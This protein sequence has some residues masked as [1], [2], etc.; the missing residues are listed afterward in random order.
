MA[1]FT[2]RD[3][4]RTAG[5]AAAALSLA[6]AV[7]ARAADRAIRLFWWGNPDRDKRTFEVIRS[8]QE[9]HPG[10]QVSGETIGWSDYWTK[11][12]TQTAGRNMPDL[13][14]MDY[15]YLFEYVRRGALKPLDDHIGKSLMIGTFDK[16]AVDGGRVDGKLYALNI[17]SNSQVMVYNAKAFEAAGVKPDIYAW[18]Y[19]DYARVCE[20]VT[21]KSGGRM[22]GSDDLSLNIDMLE[23]WIRQNGREFYDADGKVAATVEDAATF[24]QY[25]AGLRKAGVVRDKNKTVLVSPPLSETGIVTGEA[26]IGQHWSNQLVGIQALM[27]DPIGAAMVP[28]MQNGKPGQFIKP[29]QFLS[30]S[31]DA[32]DVEAAMLLLNGWVTDPKLTAIL[33]ME[34][35]IPCSPQVRAALKP[36]LKPVEALSI[37][38][39]Q[40]IQD[41]VA[42]LPPPPPKGAGE[43]REAFTRIGTEVVLDRTSPR[44]AAD[45][46]IDEAG[47]ILERAL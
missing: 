36:S 7:P 16:A 18:T 31:R 23:A 11:M 35:G 42:P 43:V 26:A 2:R 37:D 47:S 8:F 32:K 22:K 13:V 41:K 39:F 28:F 33:G 10:I 17:G 5:A 4:L 12:A 15:R 38:F 27:K 44:Q 19:D 6:H 25:W 40:A 1:D 21:A 20:A 14:Q 34:R 46:F 3:L 30:L 9:S 29:S 45:M 24:W